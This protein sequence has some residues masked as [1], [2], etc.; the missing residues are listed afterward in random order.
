MP[1]EDRESKEVE[2]RGV[3][4]RFYD[5]IMDLNFATEKSS[6][7]DTIPEWN[8]QEIL[9]ALRNPDTLACGMP[10]R[11]DVWYDK[12][13]KVGKIYM[14]GRKLIGYFNRVE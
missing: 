2:A 7:E 11:L 1:K 8:G 10:P 14:G 4:I 13:Q 3:R 12:E 9:R 5:V 6:W